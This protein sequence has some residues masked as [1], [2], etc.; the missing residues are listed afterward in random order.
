MKRRT[1]EEWE[2]DL[3][4]VQKNITYE[5]QLRATQ[6]IAANMPPGSA[7]FKTWRDLLRLALSC[8]ALAVGVLF[9][10]LA[11]NWA[12]HAQQPPWSHAKG[13]AVISGMVLAGSATIALGIRMFLRSIR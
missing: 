13:Y 1:R 2:R 11:W 3:L 5:D 10:E 7:P 6:R 12:S 9:L 8:I 4:D